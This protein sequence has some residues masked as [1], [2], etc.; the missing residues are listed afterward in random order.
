MQTV[1]IVITVAN[2][3]PEHSGTEKIKGVPSVFEIENF[4]FYY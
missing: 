3:S 1:I 2:F 4:Y